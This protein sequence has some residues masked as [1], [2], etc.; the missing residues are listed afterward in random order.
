MEDL[1]VGVVRGPLALGA[2]RAGQ[3]VDLG[4]ELV[5]NPIFGGGVVLC[6]GIGGRV[7]ALGSSLLVE[8][9]VVLVGGSIAAWVVFV[10]AV[11]RFALLAALRLGPTRGFVI[12]DESAWTRDSES[13]APFL[14]LR[15]MADV[16]VRLHHHRHHQP[17]RL[18]R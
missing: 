11:A 17:R 3:R 9:G 18:S 15:A 6:L 10:F 12:L 13:Y 4:Q 8:L 16:Q 7:L 1:A 2:A 14:S 5:L